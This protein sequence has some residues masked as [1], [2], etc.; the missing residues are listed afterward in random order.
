ME[1]SVYVIK[2]STNNK[3]YI[4]QTSNLEN[5]LKRH[6]KVLKNKKTSYTSKNISNGIWELVYKEGLISR[7]DAL[8]REKELKS[9]QG[10]LFIK[11]LTSR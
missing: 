3:I 10:R 9:Y 5:R 7:K 6:N 8:K 11:N 4:G 1:F 2:N